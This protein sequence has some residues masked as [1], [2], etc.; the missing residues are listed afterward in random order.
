M[1]EKPR[2]LKTRDSGVMADYCELMIHL[3]PS[4]VPGRE[5]DNVKSGHCTFSTV[6]TSTDEAHALLVIENNW[7]RLNFG[8]NLKGEEKTRCEEKQW[9][10]KEDTAMFGSDTPRY[11]KTDSGRPRNGRQGKTGWSQDGLDRFNELVKLVRQGRDTS[12]SL[13]DTAVKDRCRDIKED[14]LRKR[15]RRRGRNAEEEEA[16]QKLEQFQVAS[17]FN[18]EAV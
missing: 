9:I 8:G 1:M 17:D 10:S 7:N 16:F 15:K 18:Y 5:W 14:K 11:T 13:F 3:A 12:G 4:M 6:V 2:L